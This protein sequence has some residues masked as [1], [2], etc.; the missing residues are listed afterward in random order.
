MT[1]I[2]SNKKSAFP[3]IT[4]VACFVFSLASLS[5]VTAYTLEALKICAGQVIPSLFFFLVL[6]GTMLRIGLHTRIPVFIS[7]PIC[8]ALGISSP[9]VAA[10]ILGLLCGFP[11][12]GKIAVDLYKRKD[13]EKAEAERLIAFSNNTGPAFTVAGIGT[14]ILG[15]THAG[16]MI[17][18]LQIAAAVCVALFLRR[19]G[20][21]SQS[22]PRSVNYQSFSEA[23]CEAIY[24]AASSCLSICGFII[25][26]Y[27]AVGAVSSRLPFSGAKIL[28]SSI[29]EVSSGANAASALPTPFSFSAAAF[30]VGWSG[31]SVHM[32]TRQF[33]SGTDLSMKKYYIS[34]LFCGLFCGTGALL[35]SNI[36]TP[37]EPHDS[38]EA[39]SPQI[40]N[41]IGHYLLIFTV[42]LFS[43][44]FVIS[45]LEKNKKI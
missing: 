17:Y 28:F 20:G 44:G 4:V 42:F 34:K 5:S 21:I 45:K 19:S 6:T 33:T 35:I 30:S 3:A 27:T 7:R 36:I 16:V 2:N 24:D 31:I 15:S 39:F 11:I 43:V 8:R 18:F 25:F 14:A 41:E 22:K 32:Q 9:S 37:S 10:F 23:L 38:L 26:F 12:G 29:C 1:D 13:I 40:P